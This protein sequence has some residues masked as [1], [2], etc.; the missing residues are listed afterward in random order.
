MSVSFSHNRQPGFRGCNQGRRRT[1][2]INFNHKDFRTHGKVKPVIIR[3]INHV[4][5]FI[6]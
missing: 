5:D 2:V 6:F 1:S 3:V 4:S